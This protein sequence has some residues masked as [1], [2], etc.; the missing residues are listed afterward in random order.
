MA[1]FRAIEN[2]KPVL[3]AANTGISG[4]IDSNGRVLLSTSFLRDGK[5]Q[6]K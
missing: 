6:W 3:R 2:R 5:R 1:V 4:Y